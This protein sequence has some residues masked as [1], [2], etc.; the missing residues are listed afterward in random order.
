MSWL[1]G[2]VSGK[3]KREEPDAVLQHIRFDLVDRFKRFG[4]TWSLSNAALR[5]HPKP[6]FLTLKLFAILSKESENLDFGCLGTVRVDIRPDVAPKTCALMVRYAV[7]DNTNFA[8]ELHMAGH[9][10]RIERKMVGREL[11]EDVLVPMSP[12]EWTA[13]EPECFH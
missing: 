11:G 4:G 12:S 6:V 13:L 2:I 1:S 8:L 7:F 3:R 5:R 10:V 9:P